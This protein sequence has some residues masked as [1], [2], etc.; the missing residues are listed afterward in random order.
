MPLYADLRR[1]M[2]SAIYSDL[3]KTKGKGMTKDEIKEYNPDLYEA[4][5]G[6]G[7]AYDNVEKMKRELKQ[8]QD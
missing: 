2:N 8:L 3:K 6:K 5:Y 4:I 1:M 7:S